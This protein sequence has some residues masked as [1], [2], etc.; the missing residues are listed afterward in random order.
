MV[1]EEF[2][3]CIVITTWRVVIAFTTTLIDI[4]SIVGPD[5]SGEAL[6]SSTRGAC[7]SVATSWFIFFKNEFIFHI[8]LFFAEMIANLLIA[9]IYRRISKLAIASF[10][11]GLEEWQTL[12]IAISSFI[13]YEN[14][15]VRL[16]DDASIDIFSYI[17]I[18]CCNFFPGFS[19]NLI[20][21]IS[22]IEFSAIF[23]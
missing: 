22:T 11:E 21:Q 16:L 13:S 7:I 2:L 18:G 3:G 20:A 15:I 23:A 9:S 4:L 6:S 1:V 8:I 5:I 17:S 12:L 10:S 19:H 14:I